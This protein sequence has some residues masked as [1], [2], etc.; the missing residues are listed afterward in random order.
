MQQYADRLTEPAFIN[1]VRR[2]ARRLTRNQ[3]LADDLYQSTVLK[4]LEKTSK[5]KFQETGGSFIGWVKIL[6]KHEFANTVAAAHRKR[7]DQDKTYSLEAILR[8]PFLKGERWKGA[9]RLP[10][11]K[12]TQENYVMLLEAEDALRAMP[13]QAGVITR[14]AEG[15]TL[16]EAAAELG[17]PLMTACTR[18]MRGRNKLRARLE[19]SS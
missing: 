12:D 5:G 13:L 10:T 16:T 11:V 2:Y 1:E 4:A 18:L 19:N 14:V 6:M 7:C 8:Q 15:Y 3:D 9:A 17:I